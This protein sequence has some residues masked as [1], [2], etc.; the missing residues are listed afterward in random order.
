[1]VV[2]D[3]VLEDAGSIAFIH[4]QSVEA[5]DCTMAAAL[6]A[7]EVIEQLQAP[8]EREAWLVLLD[9]QAVVGWG[10]VKAY[11]PRPGYRPACETSIFLERSLLGQGHGR[12]L[13]QALLDR[14]QGLGYHHVV[15]KIWAANQ[16]S[17]RFHQSFGFE[18]VGIQREIGYVA[19]KWRDVA[20][21]QLIHR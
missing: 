20:L 17:L 19:G 14:S 21:M 4:R 15:A 2:R 8:K 13:Q 16:G 3:A 1:M 18:L 5:A 7:Q 9:S 6:T 12:A 11:S 10:V